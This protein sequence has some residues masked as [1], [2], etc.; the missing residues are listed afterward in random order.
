MYKEASMFLLNALAL[1]P[2]AKHIWSYLEAAWISDKDVENLRNLEHM[3]VRVFNGLHNVHGFK[4]LPE[5]EGL[6][7]VNSF[8]KYL[9]KDSI[10]NWIASSQEQSEVKEVKE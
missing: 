3:D 4:D 8:E 6:S 10:D 1:N 2:K 7:Y 5:P 9:L